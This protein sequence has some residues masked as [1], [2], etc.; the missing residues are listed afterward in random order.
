MDAVNHELCDH[1]NKS[2]R[3]RFYRTLEAHS[4][5]KLGTVERMG[6][7]EPRSDEEKALMAQWSELVSFKILAKIQEGLQGLLGLPEKERMEVMK[8]NHILSIFSKTHKIANVVR[9]LIENR[10]RS[11]QCACHDLRCICGEE[12]SLCYIYNE[13][14]GAVLAVGTTCIKTVKMKKLDYMHCSQCNASIQGYSKKTRG[15]CTDCAKK[16]LIGSGAHKG[17]P[18]SRVPAQYDTEGDVDLSL[19]DALSIWTYRRS[20][21]RCNRAYCV[22]D[23]RCGDCLLTGAAKIYEG[24]HKGSS[25]IEAY[26]RGHTSP[27]AL[28][29]TYHLS[30]VEAALERHNALTEQPIGFTKKHHDKTYGEMRVEVGFIQW[31]RQQPRTDG[32]LGNLLDYIDCAGHLDALRA[33]S[34]T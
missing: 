20:L 19:E 28:V 33:S 10:A 16:V 5:V 22:W 2:D 17:S 27:D 1:G 11:Y 4:A 18:V 15:R 12:S 32:P 3:V 7:N 34:N 26:L 21:E 23:D 9:F 8:G 13:D 29:D 24:P 14:T 30:R 25:V 6:T 31:A